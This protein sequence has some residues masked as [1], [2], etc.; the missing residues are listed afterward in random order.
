[1]STVLPRAIVNWV[2]HIMVTHAQVGN[3][4]FLD[5]LQGRNGGRIPWS[6]IFSNPNQCSRIELHKNLFKNSHAGDNPSVNLA[7]SNCLLFISINI[8]LNLIVKYNF[9][10]P[11][12]LTE[13]FSA[14]CLIVKMHSTFQPSS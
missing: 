2:F 7:F 5:L 1:M 9:Y 3:I 14:K 8:F 6:D 4:F 11:T 12:I 13:R 10:G